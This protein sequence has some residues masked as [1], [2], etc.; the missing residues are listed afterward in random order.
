MP[1]VPGV[2]SAPGQRN[3]VA[4]PPSSRTRRARDSHWYHPGP[5]PFGGPPTRHDHGSQALSDP[6]PPPPSDADDPPPSDPGTPPRSDR[7]LS[8]KGQ[9]GATR[10]AAFRLAMAHVDLAKAEAAEIGGQIARVAAL[11][12]GALGLVI[13]AVILLVVGS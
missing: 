2:V 13:F 6:G 8:L 3:G 7:P 9:I 5:D 10:D 12:G 4:M 1:R 11:I